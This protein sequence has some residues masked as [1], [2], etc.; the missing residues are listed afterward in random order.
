MVPTQ[1]PQ[2]GVRAS[3]HDF[4]AGSNL[5]PLCHGVQAVSNKTCHYCSNPA[6]LTVACQAVAIDVCDTH[7]HPQH[8]RPYTPD[9]VRVD[10]GDYFRA[11][12]DVICLICGCEYWRHQPVLGYEWL[13]KLCD[14]KLVK[15]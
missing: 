15:L 11:S 12:G 4:T 14:G 13:N 7:E 6:T 9:T 8:K 3:Y 5:H 1:K 2:P 10:R